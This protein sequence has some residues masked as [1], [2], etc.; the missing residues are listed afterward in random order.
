MRTRYSMMSSL[1]RMNDSNPTFF[2]SFSELQI[3]ADN[4]CKNI[5]PHENFDID[6]YVRLP[7]FVQK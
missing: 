3:I 1:W 4:E 6:A 7:W 5:E 2:T